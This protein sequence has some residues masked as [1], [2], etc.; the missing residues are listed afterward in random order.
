M[1]DFDWAAKTKQAASKNLRVWRKKKTT[2]KIFQTKFEF[3]WS[4]SLWKIDYFQNFSKYFLDFWLGSEII[5]LWKMTLVS[6]NIFSDFGG[7]GISP[8]P[9]G[10]A[11]G[12]SIQIS[13]IMVNELHIK[14]FG[15]WKASWIANGN[16][17]LLCEKDTF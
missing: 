7:W 6:Y 5:D 11:L 3:F 15:T 8:L 12:I 10:Y 1:K 9:P 17:W 13:S 14:R 4:K 2:L 16:L